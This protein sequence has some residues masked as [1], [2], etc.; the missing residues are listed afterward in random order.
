MEEA[1]KSIDNFLDKFV[2]D[3]VVLPLGVSIWISS[4]TALNSRELDIAKVKEEIFEF[5]ISLLDT[6][7][8]DDGMRERSIGRR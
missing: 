4:E 6:T 2:L 3:I 5:T 8:Q 7:I 1:L